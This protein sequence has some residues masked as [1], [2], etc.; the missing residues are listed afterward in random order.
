MLVDQWKFCWTCN[1]L[2][3]MYD[4]FLEI[5]PEIRTNLT[6]W[7]R[8]THICVSKLTI[9]GSDNVLS[10]DRRQAIIWTNAGIL[11]IGRIG[12]NFSEILIE[13]LT[14]WLKKMRFKVLSAK[15]RPFYLCLNVL[16][17]TFAGLAS[18]L[19]GFGPLSLK[20]DV[21]LHYVVLVPAEHIVIKSICSIIEMHFSY[22]YLHQQEMFVWWRLSLQRS[23]IFP[24]M[25][26]LRTGLFN[27]LKVNTSIILMHNV[28]QFTY[29][30]LGTDENSLG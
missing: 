7:G 20:T 24:E 10:P 4:I 18:C 5:L 1:V 19:Y 23:Y 2:L 6:H 25:R 22:S 14:F 16:N 3:I 26:S 12:T 9:I 15:R 21:I 11:L 28:I 17:G 27:I 30:D 8:V 13:I 29:L